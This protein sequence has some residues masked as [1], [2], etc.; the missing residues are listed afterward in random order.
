MHRHAQCFSVRQHLFANRNQTTWEVQSLQ[1]NLQSC[2]RRHSTQS[3][4]ANAPA[5]SLYDRGKTCQRSVARSVGSVHHNETF[6]WPFKLR[7]TVHVFARSRLREYVH[8]GYISLARQPSARNVG[9]PDCRL[10]LVGYS[11][12]SFLGFRRPR[13]TQ[14]A[15]T[16]A[17]VARFPGAYIRPDT[18]S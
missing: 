8:G 13:V 15:S 11:D 2:G 7:E 17:S 18:P 3:Q 4:A 5:S 16:A 1:K 12:F 10:W 9:S 14:A 6:K